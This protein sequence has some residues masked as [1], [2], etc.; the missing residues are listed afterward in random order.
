MS[1]L[2]R[3]HVEVGFDGFEWIKIVRKK[4]NKEVSVPILNK[5]KEILNKYEDDS[6]KLL[7]VISNQKFNSYLK[8]IAEIVG[9]QKNLTH[10][11]ARKTFATTVL[12]YNDVPMEI[13]SELLGHSEMSVTQAHYGKIVKVKVSEHMMKLSKKLDR[14]K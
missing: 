14:K 6:E 7:P 11:L 10:H 5:A 4:T 1:S 12:L 3:R 8:E 13:V 2:E 9:I